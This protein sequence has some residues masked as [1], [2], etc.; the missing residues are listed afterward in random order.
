MR[1]GTSIVSDGR[2]A[3]PSSTIPDPWRPESIVRSSPQ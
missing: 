2:T 3:Q 1:H